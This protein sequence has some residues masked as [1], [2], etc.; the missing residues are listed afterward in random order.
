MRRFCLR[1]FEAGVGQEANS[2]PSQGK[3]VLLVLS[4]IIWEDETE[5]NHV[6][7]VEADGHNSWDCVEKYDLN[8][9]LS[10]F[11]HCIGED[12]IFCDVTIQKRSEVELTGKLG[13]K[14]RKADPENIQGRHVS[15]Q[16]HY[17]RMIYWVFLTALI[18]LGSMLG[19]FSFFK[20]DM[21][22]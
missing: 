7:A 18:N 17:F 12:A 13:Q 11:D 4:K 3:E 5:A 16:R 9:D 8:I 22:K 10:L 19:S 15:I 2:Y 14:Q 21:R 6:I 20:H 1:N